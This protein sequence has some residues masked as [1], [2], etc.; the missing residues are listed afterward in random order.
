MRSGRCSWA[1]ERAWSSTR[2]DSFTPA[3]RGGKLCDQHVAGAVQ[4]FL[5]AER[6]GLGGL[7]DQQAFEDL[8]YGEEA[9]V[10]HLLG[11]FAEAVFPILVATAAAL[12][13]VVEHAHHFS[14][15]SDFAQTQIAD[16][17]ERDHDGQTVVG[18]AQ[19]IEALEVAG[20]RAAAYILDRGDPM[21]GVNYLLTDLESHSRTLTQRGT[22]RNDLK[23]KLLRCQH[24]SST[25]GNGTQ[26]ID[27]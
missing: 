13:Q 12:A 21:I 27:F 1:L 25:W 9:A 7:K 22:Q 2:A 11:V 5:F 23:L 20:K 24:Q 26:L 10:A 4:H 3:A 18:E 8:G 6:E 16:V 14:V 17:R 19:Q 15:A